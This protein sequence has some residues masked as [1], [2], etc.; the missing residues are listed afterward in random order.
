MEIE[1]VDQEKNDIYSLG[2]ILFWMFFGFFPFQ[3]GACPMCPDKLMKKE[4]IKCFFAEHKNDFF[5]VF[6]M[7]V[8]EDQKKICSLGEVIRALE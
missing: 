5:D 8:D 7:M 1:D 6:C 4:K 3:K 2:I